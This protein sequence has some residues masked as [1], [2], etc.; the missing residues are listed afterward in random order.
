MQTFVNNKKK[1]EAHVSKE[2]MLVFKNVIKLLKH[3][4]KI[5]NIGQSVNNSNIYDLT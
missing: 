3:A 1:F 2:K 5:K 4:S